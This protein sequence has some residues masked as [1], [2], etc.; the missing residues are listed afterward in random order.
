[1]SLKEKWV[2]ALNYGAGNSGFCS[3]GK[4]C[5]KGKSSAALPERTFLKQKKENSMPKSVVENSI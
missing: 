2:P 3:V 1:M 5:H 4:A